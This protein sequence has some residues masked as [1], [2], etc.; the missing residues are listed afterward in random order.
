MNGI[1]ILFIGNYPPPYGGVPHHI[2][3]LTEFLA[4]KNYE[5]HVLA[6]GTQGTYKKGNI[7]IYKPS[8]INKLY[9]LVLNLIN[10]KF[11]KFF[12][13]TRIKK[14][15]LRHW[16]R[17][18][19]YENYGDK[20]IKKYNINLIIS[21]NLLSY[22]PVGHYLSKK[23]NIPHIVNIFGEIY[24]NH[25]MVEDEVF[26][27]EILE[28][29]KKIVSCSF[30]CA[31]SISKINAQKQAEIVVY[32]IDT[33]FFSQKKHK[34]DI[35]SSLKQVSFVGRISREMGVDTFLQIV[36]RLKHIEGIKF[37]IVGQHGD[38]TEYVK[39]YEKN[40]DGKL[41][42]IVNCPYIDLPKQYSKTDILIV[43]TRGDRTCS[44]LAA[45]EGM[46]AGCVVVGNKLGG[47]PELIEDGKSGYLIEP[48]GDVDKFCNKIIDLLNKPEVLLKVGECGKKIALEFYDENRMNNS[49]EK[50]ILNS[51]E[52]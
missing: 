12:K 37:L 21:Y 52:Y 41:E 22:A 18:Q 26:F 20:L 7:N 3:R 39:E 17:Y 5:C 38:M 40:S 36:K 23:Y 14:N 1:K 50:I 35:N 2:D 11:Q 13:R 46:A 4:K 30:H 49:M 29:A 51:I 33:T 45:M 32:G 48:L 25:K 16:L 24:K 44:S 43:P 47:I 28:G 15:F 6:G 42:V 31:S 9:D 34:F 10:Y 27:N 8:L 19:M